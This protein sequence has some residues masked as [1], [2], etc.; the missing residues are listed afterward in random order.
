[1]HTSIGTTKTDGKHY[2]N[3]EVHACQEGGIALIKATVS[4]ESERDAVFETETWRLIE[5]SRANRDRAKSMQIMISSA[6]A[7]VDELKT[8][9]DAAAANDQSAEQYR[10]PIGWL[11]EVEESEVADA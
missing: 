10:N 4:T 7:I 3:I 11:G 1:M 2:A 9:V 5:I 6:E 8:L